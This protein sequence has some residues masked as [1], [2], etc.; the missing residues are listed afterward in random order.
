MNDKATAN[1][2]GHFDPAAAG[3]EIITNVGFGELIGP[4]WQ[5]EDGDRMRIGFVIA[6]KHINRNK[7]LHGGMLMTL[8]DSAM[9]TTSRRATGGKR[10]ATIGLNIQLA[11][12]AR[13]GEFVEAHCEVV[14]AT[15]AVMF[16]QARLVVGKRTVGTANGIWKI[17]GET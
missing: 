16:M 13:L 17:L 5:R 10:Q 2:T 6:E 8:A 11:D 1:E 12:S 15:R 9:G 7:V 14:R 4:M 3:W